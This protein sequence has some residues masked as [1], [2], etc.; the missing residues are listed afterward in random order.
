[1]I[2][3]KQVSNIY[4]IAYKICNPAAALIA[5][6]VLCSC[7]SKQGNLNQGQISVPDSANRKLTS[8]N[9][10]TNTE[11]DLDIEQAKKLFGLITSK[12]FCEPNGVVSFSENAIYL[13]P[14]KDSPT[15][16]KF[17][18]TQKFGKIVFCGWISNLPEGAPPEA[19]VVDVELFVDGESQGRSTVDRDNSAIV[20]VDLAGKSELRISVD[21]AN[22]T[23]TCDW[24]HIGIQK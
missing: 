4:R 2:M 21:C 20:E 18:I 11:K 6:I 17:D 24:F 15:T 12:E 10:K 23:D 7:D 5:S 14:S 8:D 22:G 3:K 13:H 16:V 9:S 1:M 19:G